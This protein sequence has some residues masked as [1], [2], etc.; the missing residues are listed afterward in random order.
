MG[1]VLFNISVSLDGF[2]AGPHDEVDELFRWYNSGDTE[3]L[4]PGPNMIF[5]VSQASANLF[6]ETWPRI[7]AIVTGRR[8]FDI[9]K[10]WGG[11]PP[12]DVPHFVVTHTIPQA[13]VKPG[14]PFTF[15]TDGVTSA[16]AQAKQAAGDQDVSV[17]SPSVMQQCLQ[18]GLLDELHLDLVPILLGAGIRLF[19]HL[20][21]NQIELENMGAIE[22][23]GVTHLRFRVVK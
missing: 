15:V 14:S 10:A 1:K 23:T 3:V 7:G 21:T 4:F 20:G 8:N 22:G 12:L 9:A 6:R 18:A 11:H 17:S 19:D 2:V 16:V 13:W 5:K